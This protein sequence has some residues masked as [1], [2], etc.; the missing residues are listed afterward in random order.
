MPSTFV[1]AE[2]L[3]NVALNPK[4]YTGGNRRRTGNKT[5]NPNRSPL[6]PGPTNK[7]TQNQHTLLS[8]GRMPKFLEPKEFPGTLTLSTP[9]TNSFLQY[10]LQLRT[11]PVLGFPRTHWRCRSLAKNRHLGSS[12]LLEMHIMVLR[13]PGRTF[14]S[15]AESLTIEGFFTLHLKKFTFQRPVPHQGTRHSPPSHP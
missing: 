15:L 4:P 11:P 1:R 14:S 3:P 2:A 13:H 10:Q 9:N 8:S 5:V 6:S 7:P 12:Q